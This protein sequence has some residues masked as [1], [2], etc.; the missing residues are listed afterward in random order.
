MKYLLILFFL[1]TLT[2]CNSQMLNNNDIGLQIDIY[3]EDIGYEEFKQTVIEYSEN[4][5]YPNLINK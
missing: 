4:A 2:G 3:K 5:K 1:I